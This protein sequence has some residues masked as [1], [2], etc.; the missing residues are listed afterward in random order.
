MK[1]IL[2]ASVSAFA[3]AGAAAADIAWSG[4]ASATYDI[5]NGT[6]ADSLELSASASV[7][8][9]WTVTATVD[10]LD[11]AD[12]ALTISAT[13]GTSTLTFGAGQDGASG[14][15]GSEENADLTLSTTMGGVGLSASFGDETEVGISMDAGGATISAGM[16]TGTGDWAIGLSTEAAGATIGFEAAN[17]DD[18][19]TWEATVGVDVS[20]VGLE[21]VTDGSTWTADAT[22]VMGDITLTGGISDVSGYYH[23]GAS[24]TMDGIT[25]SFGQDQADGWSAGVDAVFGDVTASIS[26]AEGDDA[27]LE[28]AY[29]MGAAT[30]TAG[31]QDTN[32]YAT[33]A[34]DLGAG[35]SL[36][37]TYAAA[38][39]VDGDG[40]TVIP[41][42]SF[43]GVSFDF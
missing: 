42:G 32:N 4:S 39:I 18:A 37:L 33:L 15:E 43:I 40:E 5:E 20:G 17:V 29:A 25:V 14:L 16:V 36:D 27:D 26:M 6:I 38:N 28:V 35:A 2:L 12:Q 21:F 23:I 3:F 31:M 11:G 24:Y 34:Y 8:G 41:A 7:A 1:S 13:D 10:V 9:D 19:T 30:V 22:Y